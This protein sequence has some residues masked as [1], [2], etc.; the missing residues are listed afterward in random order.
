MSTSI[1]NHFIIFNDKVP[2]VELYLNSRGDI[3]VQEITNS[4]NAFYFIINKADWEEL[5]I[6]IDEQFAKK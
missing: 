4:S 3:F 2:E 6:F 5:K 1:C